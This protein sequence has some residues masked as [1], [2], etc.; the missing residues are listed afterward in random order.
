VVQSYFFEDRPMA[1]LAEQL[2]VSE[3]R[4]S[5][6]RSEAVLLLRGA[7]TAAL[8]PELAHKHE[9]PD[10]RAARRK[11]SYYANVAAHRS[12]ASRLTAPAHHPEVFTA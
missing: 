12:F 1:E 5:Q 10:G 11:E 8:E 6:L 7:L 9:R 3:S 4:I 2:G